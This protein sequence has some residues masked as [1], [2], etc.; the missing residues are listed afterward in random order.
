M[1]RGF[2]DKYVVTILLVVLIAIISRSNHFLRLIF[3]NSINY[4]DPTNYE[5]LN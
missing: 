2:V 3:Q 5:N 4:E 1:G